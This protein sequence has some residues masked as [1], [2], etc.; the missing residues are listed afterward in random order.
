MGHTA[1]TRNKRN[2]P[3]YRLINRRNCKEQT[4]C[5]K[6]VVD[7]RRIIRFILQKMCVCACV[8]VCVLMCVY[9]CWCVCVCVDVCVYVCWCVEPLKVA[10]LSICK[11]V[12]VIKVKSIRVSLKRVTPRLM[13]QISAPFERPCSATIVMNRLTFDRANYKQI[14]PTQGRG[15]I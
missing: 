5:R 13:E 4:T 1:R 6:C 7:R 12:I 10:D 14:R 8:C 2:G 11:W 3:D 15:S 9:V